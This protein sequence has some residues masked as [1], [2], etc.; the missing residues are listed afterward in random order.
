MAYVYE[1]P[2]GGF[3]AVAADNQDAAREATL[4]LARAG[5]KRIALV[6]APHGFAYTRERHLG[7]LRGLR[8]AGLRRDKR[9]ITC[10]ERP[11]E[12]IKTMLRLPEGQRPTAFFCIGDAYAM[13][14]QRFA[15]DL[16]LKVP[17]DVS[18]VGFG[19]SDLGEAA[20]SPLSTI[21]EPYEALGQTAL[22]ILLGQPCDIAAASENRYLLPRAAG[23]QEI[24]RAATDG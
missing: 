21:A 6:C 16:G 12:A 8:Q 3:P 19:N 7:Y 4:H 13:L 20:Y 11:A 23:R 22:R 14:A 10:E 1:R 5:H 2:C 15:L 24:R 18:V 9:L 17:A